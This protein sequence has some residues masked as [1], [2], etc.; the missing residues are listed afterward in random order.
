V[1]RPGERHAT[2]IGAG[3]VGMSAALHLQRESF[4]VTVIDRGPPG[5]GCSL[6]NAGMLG[7]ASC[8]PVAMPGVLAKVPR[9]LLPAGPLKLRWRLLPRLVPWLARFAAAARPARVAAIS[10]AMHALQHHLLD[11]HLDLLA[12][13]GRPE[14]V[15]RVGK[16]HIYESGGAWAAGAAGRALQQRHGIAFEELDADA[17]HRLVPELRGPVHGGIYFPDVCHCV[18]PLELVRAYAG[19]FARRGGRVLREDVRDFEIGSNGPRRVITDVG[20]HDVST[21]V[22][23]AGAWSGALARRLGARVPVESQRGYHVMLPRPGIVPALPVK[24]EDRGIILTPM[25][26][27]LRVTG[28]AEFGG[29]E[30]PPDP[31]GFATIVDHARAVMPGLNTEGMTRWMGHRPSTPDSLPVIDRSARYPNVLFAFGHGHFG[32]GLGAISGRL[33]ADLAMGRPSLIDLAPYGVGR[34]ARL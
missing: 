34:F 27:G 4:Q 25:S 20:V 26:G 11:A 23:A 24:V 5:E 29:L 1:N 14:L 6:G 3:V 8:V 31:R 9:M 32:L 17:V 16:L 15:H 12:D 19:L 13:S 30:A 22:I 2:V 33:V 28:I 7:T 21:L 10:D 18:D